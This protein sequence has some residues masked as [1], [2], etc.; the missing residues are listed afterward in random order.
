S[1]S[2]HSAA[3]CSTILWATAQLGIWKFRGCARSESSWSAKKSESTGIRS[4][5][6]RRPR[7]RSITSRRQHQRS[8]RLHL[9]LP[10]SPKPECKFRSRLFFAVWQYQH[11][12]LYVLDR[13]PGQR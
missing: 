9:R 5:R 12:P 4:E 13:G 6:R 2:A 8:T 1:R 3:S 7:T 11:A 10:S